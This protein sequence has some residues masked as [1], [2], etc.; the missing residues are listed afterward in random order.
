MKDK[1][2]DLV[3]NSIDFNKLAASIKDGKV[4]KEEIKE[5]IQLEGMADG[6]LDN[7]IEPVLDKI[8][9]DSANP[10]DNQAKAMLYPLVSKELKKLIDEKIGNQ[11]GQ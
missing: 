1:I 9:E 6:L 4:T 5:A 3:L 8:V 11:D 7:V 2:I 10:W